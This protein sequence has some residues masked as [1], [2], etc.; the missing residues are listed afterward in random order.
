[1]GIDGSGKT[2]LC[3]F[4]KD[5]YEKKGY[6][7]TLVWLRF[8]HLFS[9]PILFIGRILKLT[10]YEYVNKTRV[11]YHHFYR[12]KVLAHFFVVFQLFD[13]FLAYLRFI[14]FNLNKKNMV[15]IIDR[16]VYD[17]LI[18][19]IIDTRILNLQ[20]NLYG[21]L[22]IKLIP[23]KSK[24]ILL[25]RNQELLFRARPENKYDKNFN[26]KFELYKKLSKNKT[27]IEINNNK[28]L[29]AMLYEV[30]NIIDLE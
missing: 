17:I 30:R 12:N 27:I 20:E 15:L 14:F 23:F 13:T 18:D 2:S 16:Y 3:N 6:K 9:K 21:K 10:K 11:G 29:N 5:H 4:L 7:T 19:L 8:N 28:N 26:R 1:M 22:F 25:H 24:N